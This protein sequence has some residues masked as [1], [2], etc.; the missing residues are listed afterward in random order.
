M[1]RTPSVAFVLALV[2]QP[3]RAHRLSPIRGV[4]DRLLA[5]ACAMLKSKT[6]FQPREPKLAGTQPQIT[7]C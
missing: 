5:V 3:R 4:G 6:T 7:T 1:A 2:W